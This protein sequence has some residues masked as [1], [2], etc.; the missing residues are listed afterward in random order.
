MGDYD[1]SYNEKTDSS[2]GYEWGYISE[3]QDG[4]YVSLQ[5]N[6][7]FWIV[8][9]KIVYRFAV[10]PIVHTILRNVYRIFTETV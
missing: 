7:K 9:L 6:I 2:V 10:I 8:S 4:Y 1:F 5:N 3:S